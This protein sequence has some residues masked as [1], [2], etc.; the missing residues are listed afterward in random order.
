ML[1]IGERSVLHPR[2]GVNGFSILFF[3]F[4]VNVILGAMRDLFLGS[5]LVLLG[6]SGVFH[7]FIFY[8]ESLTWTRPATW[9]RFNIPTQEHAEIIRPMAFNQGFYNLFLALGIGCGLVLIKPYPTIGY[10]LLFSSALSMVGAGLVLYLSVKRSVRAAAMQA[11][12]P[13]CGV[14]LL[15]IGLNR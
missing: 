3:T 9:R 6:L 4:R 5:A 7:L 1:R 12:P 2:C 13:L 15:L 11:L 8:L 10:T 14:A